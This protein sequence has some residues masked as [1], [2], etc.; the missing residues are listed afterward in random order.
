MV[1]GLYPIVG[2]FL[3]QP[4]S[5]WLTRLYFVL[6]CV[7]P[8]TWIHLA[9]VFP[10]E[11]RVRGATL[12]IVAGAYALSAVCAVAVLRGLASS[13]ANL[14]PLHLTYLYGAASFVVFLGSLGVQYR[15]RRA[16]AVR[17]R[18]KAVLPG[19]M[20]AGSL[21]FFALT[22]SALS[23]RS[24]PVQFGL[25][26]TPIFSACIAYA[27]ANHDLFAVDRFV[28]QSFVYTLLSVVIVSGYALIVSLPPRVVPGVGFR[29]VRLVLFVA[30][31]FFLEPLRRW[32]QAAVDRAFY[33]TRLDYRKTI[34]RAE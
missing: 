12:A 5:I 2:V 33:R 32:I 15:R 6:E 16:A 9:A 34:G 4:E 23:S 13:P 7:F 3:Y 8:A 19:A 11:R 14:G 31:A 25:V 1:A 29:T 30:L 20:V 26:F 22:D 27:I 17:A 10:V 18:I 28:R 24:F 21:A